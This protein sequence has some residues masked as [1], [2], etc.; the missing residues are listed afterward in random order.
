M[1][2]YYEILGV[3]KTASA[4]EIKKAYRKLALKYHP[5][6]NPGDTVAEEKFKQIT[7]AYDVLGDEEKR[8]Q[9]DAGAY[10]MNGSSTSSDNTYRQYT[11]TYNNPFGED[12]WEWARK[13]QQENNENYH[14]EKRYSYKYGIKDYLLRGVL[15]LAQT[16]IALEF[17]R[18]SWLI[19]PIGPLICLGVIINGSIGA[20]NSLMEIIHLLKVKR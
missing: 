2:D 13:A 1:N 15:K 18:Y 20:V 4:D 16:V 3:S 19:F 10:S 12:F 9:Y 6:K 14:Y 7:A 8:R 11:Y 5:D 17:L